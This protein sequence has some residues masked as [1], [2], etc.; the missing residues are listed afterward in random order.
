MTDADIEERNV[1]RFYPPVSYQRY[2]AVVM[3]LAKDL[4]LRKVVDFGCST[5]KLFIHLKQLQQL[6]HYAAVDIS[7]S[8]LESAYREARPLAWDLVHRR[9][10]TLTCQLFRGSVADKDPRVAGFDVVTCIELVEHLEGEALEKMPETI[11][12]FVR[13]RLAVITTPN[14]DFNVVFPDM[15]GMR[16]WDHKFEWT[17]AQFQK[18][19]GDI[20]ERYPSYEVHYSGVGDAPSEKYQG[21]GHC[22]QIAIFRRKPCTN[23]EA[24]VKSAL[25]CDGLLKSVL[26]CELPVESTLEHEAPSESKS[27]LDTPVES[28]SEY[29][30][31]LK[32]T[33]DGEKSL[34]SA[35]QPEPYELVF[36]IIHPGQDDPAF[37]S[38]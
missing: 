24:P 25:E 32:S 7:Y 27:E 6:T 20:V 28:T 23:G 34:V 9:C 37:M 36:E 21:V 8:C 17:R 31:T 18:W 26:A 38:R 4:T 22:T 14:Q 35:P 29:E 11:F 5:G 12:G 16:H 10:H 30:A 13:P 33:P 15:E 1:V 2:D 3:L 19:C